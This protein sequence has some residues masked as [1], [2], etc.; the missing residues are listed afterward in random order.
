[1]ILIPTPPAGLDILR[2]LSWPV[3][4]S[5]G[6]VG[7]ITVSSDFSAR[8]HTI[9]L[10]AENAAAGPLRWIEV[11]HELAHCLLAE[12]VHPLFSGSVF[13]RGT[14]AH[15]LDHLAP[16]F[17]ASGDWYVDEVIYQRWPAAERTEV[18]EHLRLITAHP[19]STPELAWGAAL[20]VAQAQRYRCTQPLKRAR[21]RLPKEVITAA[22][23]LSATDPEQPRVDGLQKL[24][25]AMLCVATNQTISVSL[26]IDDG[27]EVWQLF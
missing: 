4:Y 11:Q 15:L 16:I 27:L 5:H 1:M 21:K 14:P 22:G 13:T 26:V 20:M 8:Q 25:N 24:L 18:S 9:M 7:Y 3:I 12:R 6:D 17:R 10:P 23:I 19:I 2:E